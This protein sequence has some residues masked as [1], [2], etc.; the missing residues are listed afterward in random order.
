M[1]LVEVY[2]PPT[3]LVGRV[4]QVVFL[5]TLLG[6]IPL[7]F[8]GRVLLRTQRRDGR[9]SATWAGARTGVLLQT[10][11][12]LSSLLL[13][14]LFLSEADYKDIGQELFGPLG[15]ILGSVCVNLA[16]GALGLRA[17]IALAIF[18]RRT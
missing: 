18:D 8:A 15:A 12:V 7:A 13:A 3:S 16:A 14:A 4:I 1:D 17:W 9:R 2:G 6:A 5:A 10:C 11:G